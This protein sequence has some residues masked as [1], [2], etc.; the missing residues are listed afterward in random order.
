MVFTLQIEESL[1]ASNVESESRI[2]I[3]KKKNALNF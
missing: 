1:Q 3:M 2:E